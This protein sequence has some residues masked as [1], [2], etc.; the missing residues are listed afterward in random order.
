[1]PIGKRKVEGDAGQKRAYSPAFMSKK[2][3]IQAAHQRVDFS[4]LDHP[5]NS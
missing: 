1:L 4:C 5:F 3:E 2:G